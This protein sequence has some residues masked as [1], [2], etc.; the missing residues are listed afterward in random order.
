MKASYILDIFE[1]YQ[2]SKDALPDDSVIFGCDCGCGG[3]SYDF[4]EWI[5]LHDNFKKCKNSL[6][7][8]LEEIGIEW[9]L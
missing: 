8:V 1:E 9:D 5:E 4:E 7:N 2:Y 3:G 6:K